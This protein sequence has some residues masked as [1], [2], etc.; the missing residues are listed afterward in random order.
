MSSYQNSENASHKHLKVQ[1]MK[2]FKSKIDPDT[3][4]FK[5][6]F[7]YHQ[8]LAQQL[9]NDLAKVSEGGKEFSGNPSIK[10]KLLPRERVNRLL[11]SGSPFLEISPM[12]A[13]GLYE[14]EVPAA[15]IICGIGRVRKRSDGSGQ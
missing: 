12:A 4:G 1:N 5:N 9:K 3:E 15:G 11:D 8:N 13:Y 10:G 6:N 2:V 7:Q 14:N